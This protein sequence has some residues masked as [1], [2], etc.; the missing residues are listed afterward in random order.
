MIGTCASLIIGFQGW[1]GWNAGF[2]GIGLIHDFF[3]FIDLFH[4]FVGRTCYSM[5][6][7]GGWTFGFGPFDVD[8]DRSHWP[9]VQVDWLLVRS[10]SQDQIFFGYIL[11]C[12]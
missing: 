10:W 9:Q 11:T 4:G 6:V 12:K 1:T 2:V 7:H 5:N 3:S 8:I